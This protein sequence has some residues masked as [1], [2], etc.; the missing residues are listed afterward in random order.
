[1]R[2][3]KSRPKRPV[4]YILII[5]VLAA[6]S[7]VA[8]ELVLWAFGVQSAS[9]AEAAPTKTSGVGDTMALVDDIDLGWALKKGF[10]GEVFATRYK[11]NSLGFRGPEI[12]RKKPDGALRVLC[13]GDSSTYG[14]MVPGHQIYPF[15]LQGL[16]E[17][18]FWPRKVEVVNTG[19]AA[20]T[21]LQTLL[22]LTRKGFELEPDLVTLCVGIN[23][24]YPIPSFERTDAQKYNAW[25]RAALRV[26]AGLARMRTYSLLEKAVKRFTEPEKPKCVV[27]NAA[28]PDPDEQSAP[29]L[30]PAM[31]TAPDS[32]TSVVKT[33]ATIAEYEANLVE[34]VNECRSRNIPLLLF[35][36]S[37]PDAHA[38]VMRNVAERF[39]VPFMDLEPAFAEKTRQ[40]RQPKAV[41]PGAEGLGSTSTSVSEHPNLFVGVY[42][43]LLSPAMIAAHSEPELFLDP[44]HPSAT[45]HRLIA[46]HLANAIIERNLLAN[47]RR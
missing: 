25:R 2:P 31:Q 7:V 32:P 16:L 5:F 3:S 42:E 26:R 37:L 8:A 15:I 45:G 40:V 19:V 47:A 22:V 44:C 27:L 30:P 39:G 38:E 35:S 14:L 13:L 10:N 33:R 17:Q 24:N 41:G 11:I 43:K 46:E 34:I 23:D 29:E 28:G 6:T 21:S 18:K 20:Y 4:L 36:F 12:E 1:M 9:T